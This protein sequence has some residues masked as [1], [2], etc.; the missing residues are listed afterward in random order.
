M[1]RGLMRG[2]MGGGMGGEAMMMMDAV[3]APQAMM[4]EESFAAGAAPPAAAKQMAAVETTANAS[5]KTG[6]PGKT[7]NNVDL[8]G[9]APRKNLNETAFFFPNLVSQSD[10]SIKL[11]FTMPE[12]L[13]KWKFLA[14][15]HDANA[16]SGSLSDQVVTSKDI[17]VQPNAPRFLREGDEIEFTA[18][19]SN[20]SPT[21]QTGSIRLSFSDARTNN[22]VDAQFANE[23]NS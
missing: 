8:S 12:A 20:T 7:A 5:D 21:Q 11:E 10:G 6:E 13:T 19:V 23:Q 22:V 18:K 2:R 15:A 14:F 17:M 3:A 9:V 4:V 1:R 16:R